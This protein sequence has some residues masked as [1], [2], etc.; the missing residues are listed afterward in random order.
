VSDFDGNRVCYYH[1]RRAAEMLAEMP[2]RKDI[3]KEARKRL[4]REINARAFEFDP[5]GIED[6]PLLPLILKKVQLVL[7]LDMRNQASCVRM[8]IVEFLTFLEICMEVLWEYKHD[9]NDLDVLQSILAGDASA[10][11]FRPNEDGASPMFVL[12]ELDNEHLDRE[13]VDR[14]LE[15]TRVENFASAQRDYAQAW[16]NYAQGDLDGALVDAHKAFESAAKVVIKR[17]DPTSTPEQMQTN[18]LVPE[19][20]RLEIIPSKL[21]NMLN[22]LVQVFQNAGCL[23]NAPGTGH[24]SI[25]LTSPEANV[26][27]LG[28]HLSGSLVFF[29]AQ[30]W[31]SMKPKS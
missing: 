16:K 4:L 25:D 23:R 1:E 20:K 30:R 27:L 6:L 31:E 29:L 22:P 24:G 11:R 3:S 12:E 26:A 19:L 14:T 7:G 13:I 28:L 10:F 9:R 21:A 18:Q 17:A 15:L 5:F 8:E 2:A